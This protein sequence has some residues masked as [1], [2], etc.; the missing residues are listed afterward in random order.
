M[1]Y[2]EGVTICHRICARSE[3]TM[4]SSE[5][6]CCQPTYIYPVSLKPIIR[7]IMPGQLVNKPAPTR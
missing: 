5:N 7:E 6:V 1:V 3:H 2:P 4:I